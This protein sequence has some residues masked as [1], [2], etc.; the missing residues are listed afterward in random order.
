MKNILKRL[1]KKL[2]V[3]AMT[4]V[5][6]A[7]MTSTAFAA[8]GP[9]RPT[10]AWSP[11]VE[12]FDHVTFNSFTGVGNG[13]GDERDFLR[14]VQVGR[15]SVWSDPV[16]NVTQDAEVEAKIYIH[17]NA[18]ARLNDQPGNP[19]VAKN[20]NVRVALPTGVKQTQDTT[21][22]ISASNAN[23]GTVFDTLTVTGA[24]NGYFALEYLPGTAKL[25][26]GTTVTALSDSLVTSGVNI[27]DQ[28]GCFE[29]VR[30]VTF[31]MKVKM[32]H[33]TI[34]KKVRFEGQT[35]NDWKESLDVKPGQIVEW[36]IEF[37]NVG[38][39]QLDNVVILD[40]LPANVT[41]VPGSVKRIDGNY[42][43]GYVY[44]ND[45]VQNN[46]TQININI[47]KV[48]PGINSIIAFKTKVNDTDAL[49][50]KTSTLVNTAYAT[51]QGFS[52]IHDAAQVVVAQPACQPSQPGELPNTGAGDVIGMFVA[53]TVA[54][55][56]VH[57]FILARRYS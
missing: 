36:K 28:K 9:S 33:Y 34:Q 12:G 26:Q 14:G 38:R 35:A 52:P 22:Y 16:K 4:L 24:N 21:A 51:P 17:N 8:F 25:H 1:P 5:F 46:G 11:N 44:G 42:P 31:R 19:G 54:G 30:E 40:Q 2:L 41:V 20:V 45:A 13:I 53:V 27:G 57:R 50:C 49:K 29:Y 3:A 18:D 15:D 43:N 47:G 10:K 6:I 48:N 32:P 56:V 23:P 7:S 55:A 37:D 39:T